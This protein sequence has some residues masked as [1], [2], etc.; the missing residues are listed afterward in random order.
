MRRWIDLHAP[1]MAALDLLKTNDVSIQTIE[2][3][4]GSVQ[5]YHCGKRIIL[6][7]RLAVLHIE[8]DD[9]ERHEK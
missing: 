9:S 3:S 6:Y 7:P 1:I 8:C 2:K 4:R 5:I